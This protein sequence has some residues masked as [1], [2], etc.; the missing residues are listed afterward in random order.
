VF[1]LNF[2]PFLELRLAL[3]L[4]IAAGFDPLLSLA[5]CI[6]MNLLVAP[7]AFGILDLVVPPIRRRWELVDRLYEWA[8]RRAKKH[9]HLGAFGLFLFVGV[10]LPGT[11][12][13][14][15][16]LVAHVAGLRRRLVYPSIC[17]GVILAG[18]S[19]WVLASAGI[20]FISGID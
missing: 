18:V 5:V 7:L 20:L 4:A 15:G 11:G 17:G 19:L 6:C 1:I 2:V 10:P 14:A 12:A 8:L 9:E 13:Y 16:T 3:P